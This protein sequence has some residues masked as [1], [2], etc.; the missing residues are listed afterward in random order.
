VTERY[1]VRA[2]HPAEP[3]RV[4]ASGAG[5]LVVRLRLATDLPSRP[6]R[7]RRR[8]G[9]GHRHRIRFEL[10]GL[11]GVGIGSV[12]GVDADGLAAAG[13]V[14]LA[15]ADILELSLPGDF[16]DSAR[17][18]LVLDPSISPVI[19]VAVDPLIDEGDPD[20]AYVDKVFMVVW[21]KA[22]RA[23]T[24][25]SATVPRQGRR[26]RGRPLGSRR[27]DTLASHPA[28]AA[29]AGTHRFIVVWRQAAT[30]W[31]HD[32]RASV[33][34]GLLEQ[35]SNILVAGAVDMTSRIPTS[36]ARASRP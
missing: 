20:V 1:D 22:S 35:S 36:A 29:L 18:P 33:S 26:L 24:S 34:P 12:R 21:D 19:K 23:R 17:F 8:G 32:I 31:L 6:G 7:P 25:T 13:S 15:A 2:G 11:G 30:R 16:V 10:P 27:L 9:C 4:G 28:I 14:R 5:D 3:V